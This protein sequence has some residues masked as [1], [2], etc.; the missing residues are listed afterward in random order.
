MRVGHRT[1]NVRGA[2]AT[3]GEPQPRRAVWPPRTI[4]RT[5]DAECLA[6]VSYALPMKCELRAAIEARHLRDEPRFAA[7]GYPLAGIV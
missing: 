4:E 1:P 3:R 2:R 7:H 6:T 5:Q